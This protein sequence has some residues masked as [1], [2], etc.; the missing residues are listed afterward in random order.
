MMYLPE[1]YP[2]TFFYEYYGTAYF[3]VGEIVKPEDELASNHITRNGEEITLSA[4]RSKSYGEVTAVTYDKG[5]GKGTMTVS[6]VIRYNLT[7]VSV[8][9][10]DLLPDNVAI[11]KYGS[12]TVYTVGGGVVSSVEDGVV[13][14]RTAPTTTFITRVKDSSYVSMEIVDIDDIRP[15]NYPDTTTINNMIQGD[16][17][18]LS[19]GSVRVTYDDGTQADF[20]LNSSYVNIVNARVESVNTPLDISA[21][22]KYELWIVYGGV[23][24]QHVSFYIEVLRKYPVA[25]HIIESTNN[26]VGR[27][28][29]F[30]DSV[31]IAGLQ[32]Y[33]EFNNDTESEPE[34]VTKDM[35]GDNCTLFCSP[36]TGAYTKTIYFRLPEKYS[37]LIPKDDETVKTD[38]YSEN[39]TY[40]VVPQTITTMVT[41][42]EPT[43][44]YVATSSDIIY[45]GAKYEVYYRNGSKI[46]IT[47]K[48]MDS[49]GGNGQLAVGGTVAV[50]I[51][52]ASETIDSHTAYYELYLDNN[53]KQYCY[54]VLYLT[55]DLSSNPN[56]TKLPTGKYFTQEIGKDR[57]QTTSVYNSDNTYYAAYYK[58]D[59]SAKYKNGAKLTETYYTF[60]NGTMHAENVYRSDETY[61]SSLN[62]SGKTRIGRWYDATLTYSDSYYSDYST[63]I[64]RDKPMY[65]TE[66]DLY[67]I[68]KPFVYYTI[69]DDKRDFLV[70]S[71]KVNC[72][73]NGLV[74]NYKYEYSQYEEWDFSGITVTVKTENDSTIT[75]NADPSMVYDSTTSVIANG[76]PVKFAYMG[77]VDETSLKVNVVDRKEQSLQLVIT[78]KDSYASGKAVDFSGYT[79]YKKYSG[80]SFEVIENLTGVSTL[81]KADGWWYTLFFKWYFI[82]NADGKIVDSENKVYAGDDY[83]VDNLGY[84]C[85]SKTEVENLF[86]DSFAGFKGY[87]VGYQKGDQ[88]TAI[89]GLYDEMIVVLHHSVSATESRQAS[90]ISV[91][92]PIKVKVAGSSE[93]IGIAYIGQV[94][95]YDERG[96]KKIKYIDSAGLVQATQPAGYD[97]S[98]FGGSVD[99]G[100]AV[101]NHRY[102]VVVLTDEGDEVGNVNNKI[103]VPVGSYNVYYDTETSALI[104]LEKLLNYTLETGTNGYVITN[105]NGQS[106]DRSGLVGTAYYYTE[107][108]YAQKALKRFQENAPYFIAQESGKYVLKNRLGKFVISNGHSLVF[109]YENRLIALEKANALNATEGTNSSHYTVSDSLFVLAE[110]VAK[111]DVMLSEYDINLDAVVEKELTVYYDDGEIE[112]I[113]IT[114]EMLSYD[115]IDSSEEYRR[116]TVSYM[117]GTC[118]VFVRVWKATLSEVGIYKTPVTNYIRGAELDLTGG[119]LQLDFDKL[120]SSGNKVGTLNKYI[121]MKN[122]D[123]S[124]SG[125]VNNIYSKEGEE[126]TISLI[127]KDYEELSTSFVIKVYDYQDVSFTFSDTISFYGT[128]KE[129]SFTA[130][131]VISE[132]PLPDSSEMELFYVNQKDFITYKEYQDVSENRKKN[133]YP[134]TVYD[135]EKNLALLYYVEKSLVVSAHYFDPPEGS[136]YAVY[137]AYVV[138]DSKGNI[139]ERYTKPEYEALPEDLPGFK[140][141]DVEMELLT[142]A[143]R[144]VLVESN[145]AYY[146]DYA[147]YVI[148]EE[149]EIVM[150]YTADEF[151]ALSR[152]DKRRCEE[153]VDKHLSQE[154]YDALADEDKVRCEMKKYYI[155][156]KS[157]CEK[158]TGD[159]D[160]L[161][162]FTEEEYNDL[163]SDEAAL[164]KKVTNQY[165]LL[166]T[167]NGE[168]TGTKYYETANYCLQSYGIIPANVTLTV[169]APSEKDY[170]LRVTTESVLDDAPYNDDLYQVIF[171][172]QNGSNLKPFVDTLKQT[173]TWVNNISVV[174]PN[175]QY[176]E[177][178]VEVF[179]EA[180]FTQE[181]LNEVYYELLHWIS[182]QDDVGKSGLRFGTTDTVLFVATEVKE[183]D[184]KSAISTRIVKGINT[185]ALDSDHSVLRSDAEL[186][187][188]YSIEYG[189]MKTR[190]G[191][192]QLLSGKLALSYDENTGKYTTVQG[193]L[194]HS[195]YTLTISAVECKVSAK[196]KKALELHV[197]DKND[198]DYLFRVYLGNGN[199]IYS[200]WVLAGKFDKKVNEMKERYD[201][202]ETITV[203]SPNKNYLE[204][205]YV[206]NSNWLETRKDELA[207]ITYELLSDMTIY[208]AEK[209]YFG[210]GLELITE[211][212]VKTTDAETAQNLYFFEDGTTSFEKEIYFAGKQNTLSDFYRTLYANFAVAT[213]AQDRF[214]VQDFVQSYYLQMKL[215]GTWNDT[216][217]QRAVLF[218][219]IY[220]VFS[221]INSYATKLTLWD[222]K[223]FGEVS[224]KAD[225][226]A[227]AQSSLVI[228]KTDVIRLSFTFEGDMF[229]FVNTA[230]SGLC[231]AAP[232]DA[233]N[234]TLPSAERMVILTNGTIQKLT[235]RYQE[236]G[237]KTAEQMD[238][239][240]AA[241]M[242]TIADWFGV[243]KIYYGETVRIFTEEYDETLFQAEVTDCLQ[244]GVN[245]LTENSKNLYNIAYSADDAEF[246]V[247]NGD[248]MLPEGELTASHDTEWHFEKGTTAFDDLYTVTVVK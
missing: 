20:G 13:A 34:Q 221:S 37:S 190:E 233:V 51:G 133:Y 68:S 84:N 104:P 220:N 160:I 76:V 180:V 82:Y 36:A 222:D 174:S 238:L 23:L 79:F 211:D 230:L 41:V 150:R 116:V 21:S 159:G 60:S 229:R 239:A 171:F 92:I 243:N 135:D 94:D 152:E 83:S 64:G 89:T 49:C 145:E 110:L 40:T 65:Y 169:V 201:F 125:F 17:I 85:R 66:D 43:K 39:Y 175:T 10:G 148:K 228:G 203:V 9:V 205:R 192:L 244:K 236:N 157:A 5:T 158:V 97:E 199:E 189:S 78:G 93:V 168:T 163:P 224:T 134:I 142:Q 186:N 88:T 18:D 193:T 47:G 231:D 8:A 197:L 11:G 127:Y 100:F 106:V 176:F 3:T 74:K 62:V 2:E 117:G 155:L 131:Q 247:Y 6:T 143:Q 44:V 235:F 167:V 241:C 225:F 108:E 123:V 71:I 63:D 69:D 218:E 99:A 202:I 121:D 115:I 35:L 105:G 234:T 191:K 80:G 7:T 136:F 165:Y 179:Q 146:I 59:L 48:D 90:D 52:S 162:M 141:N 119:I 177:F 132:F 114:A 107:K 91:D 226:L 207:S 54:A 196:Q 137:S 98:S 185:F 4:I 195:S 111:T 170:L 73:E 33:V 188:V 215:S 102:Q 55:V 216:A 75:I 200:D 232:A 173:Y 61:Y 109:Y 112:M 72:P 118:D 26:I 58:V 53:F 172:A 129:A 178:M 217:A 22:G 122:K 57:Y 19:S 198:E 246:I 183:S 204:F 77:A 31:S 164:C 209:V 16:E 130:V 113:P 45:D 213:D 1:E 166:V 120:D 223:P 30:N 96:L 138:R 103:V 219:T 29:Y 184:M 194:E 212:S 42:Q 14:I 214:T 50:N 210:K 86:N 227:F 206:F 67:K 151:A 87:S 56:N 147:D 149:G 95:E 32:Y 28:F 15:K 101:L 25:L 161:Y 81:K 248:A 187:I 240:F 46:E 182:E 245:V 126:I 208:G 140:F 156:K 237:A 139:W 154:Q 70:K 153:V 128:V 181:E 144:N 12:N 242:R 124:N 27:R 38:I 24:E